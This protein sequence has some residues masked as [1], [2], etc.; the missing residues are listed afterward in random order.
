MKELFRVL[1][2]AL[3]VAASPVAAQDADVVNVGAVTNLPLPRFV[4]LKTEEG[5]ARRGP[6]LTHRIDWVF[7]RDGMPLMITAEHGHWRRVEDSEGAGG[8]VHYALLSGSRSALVTADMADLHADPSEDAPVVLK[9]EKDVIGSLLACTMHWC[10]LRIQG[11]EG[12][13]RKADIWGVGTD[14]VLN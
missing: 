12:W 8:W 5:N 13:V 11:D 14:E 7:K 2:A 6:G 1:V 4:T 9:A 3:V 10:D